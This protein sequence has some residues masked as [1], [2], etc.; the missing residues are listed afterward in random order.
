MHRRSLAL[1]W[2]ALLVRANAVVQNITFGPS[3][4]YVRLLPREAWKIINPENKDIQPYAI[5]TTEGAQALFTFPRACRVGQHAPIAPPDVLTRTQTTFKEPG[6]N[7]YLIGYCSQIGKWGLC[8]DCK[9][10]GTVPTDHL[11]ILLSGANQFMPGAHSVCHSLL[12]LYALGFPR[13]LDGARGFPPQALTIN[14]AGGFTL[15]L[16]PHSR[17]PYNTP[18]KHA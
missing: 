8:I 16:E 1:V 7:F 13:R 2:A 18:H 11:E 4:S 3:S 9:A 6:V 15:S 17:S 14:S 10:N 5:T 12:A